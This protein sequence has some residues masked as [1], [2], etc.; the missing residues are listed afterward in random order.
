MRLRVDARDFDGDVI[1]VRFL[2]RVEVGVEALVC[3]SI[4]QHDFTQEIHVLSYIFLETCG[5]MLSQAGS[6]SIDDNTTCIATQAPLDDGYGS[7]IEQ[8]QVGKLPIHPEQSTICIVKE[9]RNAVQIDE[10]LDA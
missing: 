10:F 8:R 7:P 5:Q 4:A 1:D 9:T 3:L 6:C 2:Y